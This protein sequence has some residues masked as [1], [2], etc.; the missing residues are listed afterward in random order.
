MQIH[1]H[2][3][4]LEQKHKHFIEPI[5]CKRNNKTLQKGLNQEKH[6]LRIVNV[7]SPLLINWRLENKTKCASQTFVKHFY[8]DK[9]PRKPHKLDLKAMRKN[10]SKEIERK[11]CLGFFKCMA[12]IFKCMALIYWKYKNLLF[13]EN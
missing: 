2:K 10:V 11:C 6:F 7:F 8:Y 4:K 9:P 3:S 1:W 12:L 5:K 13:Y